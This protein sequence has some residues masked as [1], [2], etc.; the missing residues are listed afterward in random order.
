MA[1]Y[2]FQQS[3]YGRALYAREQALHIAEAGI[4]YYRWY[5]VHNADLLDDGVGIE[6]SATYAVSDPEGGLLGSADI[7]AT[8]NVQCGALQWI[9]MVAVGTPEASPAFPRTISARYM[10]PAVSEYSYIVNSNVWAGA[11][12]DIR[13]PYHSNG[14]IRMDGTNNAEVTSAVSQWWCD[15]SFSSSLCPTGSWKPGVWGNGSG[16]ALWSYPVSTIDFETI[17]VDLDGLQT[18][19]QTYGGIHFGP[20]SGNINRRGYHLVFQNNGTVDAYR[21]YDTEKVRGYSTQ[22]NWSDEYNIIDGETFL[23]NYLIPS[24]CSVI[25]AEDRV[26][27]EGTVN[28]KVTVVAATPTNENTSPDALLR[29]N[30]L[31]ASNDGSDGLTVIAE[32]NVLLPLTTP[33]Y[34]EIHGTFIAQSGR[35]G[36][37]AYTTSGSQKVPSQYNS[38]VLQERLTTIGTIVSNQRTGTAWVCS[39]G[40]VCTGYTDRDDFYDQI[41]A[42]APAPFTPS[43][44]SDYHLVLWREE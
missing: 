28:G 35:Y 6:M 1:G 38:Y 3:I 2:V 19:V 11:D 15:S 17:A 30:I 7:V 22:D 5:L 21:V 18:R 24:D 32:R 13:G 14:G 37:N 26:W 23:G 27:I 12:R 43:V 9:D 44:S 4:E 42:F 20:A 39:G 16:S 34:M 40:V 29:D 31:Y 41:L 10:K 25:F 8:S 36:R 33:E